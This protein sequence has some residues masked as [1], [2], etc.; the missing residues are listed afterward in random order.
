MPFD[1]LHDS[2]RVAQMFEIG[3]VAKHVQTLP[4]GSECGH[5]IDHIFVQG[6]YDVTD[7]DACIPSGDVTDH[8]IVIATLER[9]D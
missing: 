4:D 1:L 3:D 2:L 7:V 5:G 6:P 9:N 8:P